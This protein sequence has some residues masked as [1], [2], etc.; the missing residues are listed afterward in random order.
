MPITLK[1][2]QEVSTASGPDNVLPLEKNA[3]FTYF[4]A[5]QGWQFVEADEEAEWLPYLNKIIHQRGSNGVDSK[6]SPNMAVAAVTSK[7]HQVIRP[8]DKRLGPYI[9]Y[10][11]SFDCASKNGQK[12]KYY[13]TAFES[14]VIRGQRVRWVVDDKGYRG[15]LRYLVEQKIVAPMGSDILEEKIEI[16]QDRITRLNAQGSNPS[17]LSK[18]SD[19]DLKIEKMRAAWERQFGG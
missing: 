3:P 1:A 5:D 15:F 7:G 16:L 4:H 11:H 12:G 14:P 6:G 8:D 18:A 9:N 10:R 2:N 19:A 17:A 13:V